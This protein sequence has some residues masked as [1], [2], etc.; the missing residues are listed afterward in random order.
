[1]SV[2][3]FMLAPSQYSAYSILRN[4]FCGGDSLIV[5]AWPY[6]ENRYFTECQSL[7]TEFPYIRMHYNKTQSEYRTDHKIVCHHTTAVQQDNLKE[8]SDQ[9]V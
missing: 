7:K 9:Y 6:G 1:M 8:Y 3:G 4:N 5:R 2:K